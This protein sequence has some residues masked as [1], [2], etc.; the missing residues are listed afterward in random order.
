MS[1]VLLLVYNYNYT[2]LKPKKILFFLLF[3]SSLAMSVGLP[4]GQSPYLMFTNRHEIRRIGLVRSDYTQVAPTLKN[5]V[6]LDVDVTTNKMYWCDLYH[7][8]IFRYTKQ[9]MIVGQRSVGKKFTT[10]SMFRE[11]NSRL[12]ILRHRVHFH[13]CTA[14][15]V[16]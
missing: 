3:P 7:R 1:S 8:K 14:P 15:G 5:A 12:E 2:T 4:I 6:A 16:C 11:S 9:N 13:I 10:R